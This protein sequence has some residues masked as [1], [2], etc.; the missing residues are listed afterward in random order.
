MFIPDRVT[1]ST[2]PFVPSSSMI[3]Q[4]GRM[5]GIAAIVLVPSAEV[6][7]NTARGISTS[8]PFQRESSQEP[9]KIRPSPWV[10]Q[11]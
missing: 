1:V 4:P 2:R 11:T 3:M 8:L 9:A 10:S 5:A 7:L 6:F